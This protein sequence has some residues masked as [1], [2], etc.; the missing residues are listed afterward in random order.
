[1]TDKWEYKAVP[2]SWLSDEQVW[3]LTMPDGQQAKDT[4]VGTLLSLWGAEGWELVNVAAETYNA[5]DVQGFN[6]GR[7]V[8]AYDTFRYRAFFKRRKP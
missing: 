4:S 1:M 2:V 8:G 7:W 5:T 3:K 6:Y